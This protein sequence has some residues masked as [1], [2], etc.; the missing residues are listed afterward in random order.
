MNDVFGFKSSEVTIEPPI[1]RQSIS[2]EC[3]VN[4]NPDLLFVIN[5]TSTIG[6]DKATNNLVS[7]ELIQKTKSFKNDKIVYLTP[8][9]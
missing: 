5:R 4:E 3:V 9:I 8:D 2:P 7:N 6:G 1:H